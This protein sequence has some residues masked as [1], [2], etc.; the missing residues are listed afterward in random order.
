MRAIKENNGIVPVQ[1]GEGL[2]RITLTSS[3]TKSGTVPKKAKINN[4]T[5]KMR[6]NLPTG[7]EDSDSK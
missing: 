2:F 6:F 1:S 3:N 4:S 7:C 5:P